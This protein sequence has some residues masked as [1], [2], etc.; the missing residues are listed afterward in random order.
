MGISVLMSVYAAELP[1]RLDRALKSVW[2]DQTLKP[3][4]IILVEDG[5]LGPDLQAV[6]ESRTYQVAQ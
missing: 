1:D 2:D 3:D 5:P 4:E 6:R